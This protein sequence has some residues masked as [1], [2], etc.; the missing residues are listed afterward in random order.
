[1]SVTVAGVWRT[2]ASV[3]A[4]WEVVSDLDSWREW[5]PAL[6]QVHPRG[7][8][9][10]DVPSAA[11]LVFETVIGSLTVP[12]AIGPVVGGQLLEVSGD[13]GGFAG[14]GSLRVSDADDGA[15]VAYRVELRTTKFWLKPIETVLR[16]ASGTAGQRRLRQAGDRL[17]ELAG[18]EPR[19]HDV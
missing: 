5:W 1:M 16:S 13:G 7:E 10:R 3:E 17:A 8:V 2:T 4:I 6:R 9:Q 14:R 15:E 19:D 18:G 12:V 11:D